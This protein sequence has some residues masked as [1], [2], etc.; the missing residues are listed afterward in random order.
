VVTQSSSIDL[1]KCHELESLSDDT[2]VLRAKLGDDLA[3]TELW[4]RHKRQT[5]TCIRRIAGNRQDTEDAFQDAC[6]KS[7]VH[8]NKFDGRSKFSTWLTRI[9][10]N[11]ALMIL[12]KRRRSQEVFLE[13]NDGM[14]NERNWDVADNSKDTA[15]QYDR[16]ESETLLNAAVLKLCP[17]LRRVVEIQLLLDAP[18]VEIADAAGLSLSA[19]KSRLLRARATL[20][21]SFEHIYGHD[22]SLPTYKHCS[23]S[24]ETRGRRERLDKRRAY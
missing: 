8:M 7:F 23:D 24:L 19:T 1:A 3:F 14:P 6:L 2:L 10:I 20:R 4:G 17:S 9:A 22:K 18:L 12:R 21:R 11:S 15:G 16:Y 13:T 5:W